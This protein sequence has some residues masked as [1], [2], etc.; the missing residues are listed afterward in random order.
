MAVAMLKN[1]VF[2]EAPKKSEPLLAAEEVNS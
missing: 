2:A 1:G